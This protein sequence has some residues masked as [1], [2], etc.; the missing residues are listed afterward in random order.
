MTAAARAGRRRP[1]QS[2]RMNKEGDVLHRWRPF[3][4]LAV[5]ACCPPLQPSPRVQMLAC[6]SS[7][8]GVIGTPRL[9]RPRF[10]RLGTRGEYAESHARVS[11]R[12]SIISS[13]CFS[14]VRSP[15][16]PLRTPAARRART[17]ARRPAPRTAHTRPR[18]P[19]S[20]RR[21]DLPYLRTLDG[22]LNKP[23]PSYQ[24]CL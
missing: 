17:G 8:R 20:H 16:G 12:L 2:A 3:T 24:S 5:S 14:E 1:K 15:S 10:A 4:R 11:H 19:T 18:A 13:T 9:C 7:R 22:S 6:D 23:C 21:V